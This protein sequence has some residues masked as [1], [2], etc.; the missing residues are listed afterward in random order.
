M[1]CPY[2]GGMEHTC[3]TQAS[4]ET[5]AEGKQESPTYRRRSV[6]LRGHD[7]A[8]QGAY[9]VTICAAD[10]RCVFGEVVADAMRSN[11][12]GDIVATCWNEIPAH[13]P[14]VRLDAFVLMPNHMHGILMIV[15][16][17]ATDCRGT[18]CRAPTIGPPDSTPQHF[19]VPT[20]R[21]LPTVVRSFKAAVTKRVHEL[22]GEPDLEIWQRNYFEHVIRNDDALNEIRRY[23]QE[24][25]L[26][27]ALDRENPA[28]IRAKRVPLQ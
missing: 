8:S 28:N 19:G 18:T 15:N 13:F 3:A 1:S 17:D 22:A 20:A 9:F 26:R 24:N 14:S 5:M 27:W 21:S 25:P 2:D 6:R 16:E 11:A 10:L 23:I 12:V 7:Y 4:S